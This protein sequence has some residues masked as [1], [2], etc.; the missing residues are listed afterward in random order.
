MFPII[1]LYIVFVIGYFIS[2]VGYG[3]TKGTMSLH[4]PLKVMLTITLQHPVVGMCVNELQQP[5][6]R[7]ACFYYNVKDTVSMAINHSTKHL[8]PGQTMG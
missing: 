5:T 6:V 7:I 3:V 8:S 2:D 4:C 1:N